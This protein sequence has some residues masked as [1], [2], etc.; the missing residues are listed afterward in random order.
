MYANKK[1]LITGAS[2]GLGR[3]LAISY[4]KENAKIINLSRDKFKMEEL[5]TYLNKI[6]SKNNKYYSVDVGNYDNINEVK[7]ELKKTNNLPDIII[8]NAAGNFLCLFEDLTLNGWK[9]IN[10]IVLDGAFNIYHIFGKTLIEEKKKAVFLNISTTYANESS[11]FV[12]PSAAAK[13]GVDNIMK[14]LTVEWSKYGMRFVGIAPG[15]MANTG[16]ASKLDKLGLF[17]MYN[18]VNNPSKRMCTTEEIAKLSLYLTSEKADYINGE[19]I[20]IDG[21]EFIKNQG[22]FSF[23]TNIPYYKYLLKQQK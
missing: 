16:G 12:I 1:V 8:N 23:I 13:A 2:C 17:K 9:K 11:A 20:R 14:G 15:P 21:G 6:N 4:A 19:I 22:E 18:S 5:N 10:N 7:N 3:K